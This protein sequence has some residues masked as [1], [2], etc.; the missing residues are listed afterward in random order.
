M[1]DP[2]NEV[3]RLDDLVA[4]PPA[5]SEPSALG[6]HREEVTTAAQTETLIEVLRTLPHELSQPV[7]II[8]GYAE[9]LAAGRSTD[10]A[11]LDAC[12]EL[13]EA[14]HRLVDLAQRLDRVASHARQEVEVGRDTID[15]ERAGQ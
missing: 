11:L 6:H 4:E 12:A 9:L 13:V 2:D 8:S 5:G 14:S 3:R 7:T 15:F 1:I 10:Q